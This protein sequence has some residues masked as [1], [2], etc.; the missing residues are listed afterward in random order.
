[1]WWYVQKS[2][3]L[4]QVRVGLTLKAARI[5]GK[6]QFLIGV[7][8]WV[9]INYHFFLWVQANDDDHDDDYD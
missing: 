6:I 1:M 7:S 9:T 3:T 8:K 5:V 4:T 2:K